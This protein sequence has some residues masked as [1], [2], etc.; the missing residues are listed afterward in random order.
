MQ[1]RQNSKKY[2]LGKEHDMGG[3]TR[4]SYLLI[5]KNNENFCKLSYE[6]SGDYRKVGEPQEPSNSKYNRQVERSM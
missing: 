1:N 3:R 2:S 4:N 5:N 6:Q